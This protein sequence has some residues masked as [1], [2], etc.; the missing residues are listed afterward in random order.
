MVAS[1]VQSKSH[2]ETLLTDQSLP[3]LAVG[4]RINAPFVGLNFYQVK[5]HLQQETYHKPSK[6]PSKL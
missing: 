3:H 2:V 5:I 1:C 6:G 4:Y